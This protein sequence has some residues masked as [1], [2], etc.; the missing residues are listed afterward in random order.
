[1]KGVL[2]ACVVEYWAPW[3]MQVVLIIMLSHVYWRALACCCKNTTVKAVPPISTNAAA[4][5]RINSIIIVMVICGR[6]QYHY[7]YQRYIGLGNYC[8]FFFKNL[9]L[10][11]L[12][13][14]WT[15]ISHLELPQI[16]LFFFLWL[17]IPIYYFAVVTFLKNPIITVNKYVNN[18]T[19]FDIVNSYA[20]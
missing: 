2:S 15:C 12:L 13:L 3:C 17:S 20:K 14:L 11:Y 7:H 6:L 19:S 10:K 5:A 18:F 8:C 1:M 4:A 9:F 16:L